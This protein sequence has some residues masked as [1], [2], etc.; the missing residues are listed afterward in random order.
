M[1][2]RRILRYLRLYAS[3]VKFSVSKSLQFRFDFF[4]RV[5]MDLIYYLVNIA[6]YKVI[7]ANTTALAGWDHHQIFIFV[8]GYCVV[9]AIQMTVFANNVH[10]FLTIV[11]RGDLDYHIVRPVSSLFMVGV[12]DFAVNSFLNLLMA[13]GILAYAVHASP[14]VY[15][16]TRVMLFVLFLFNGALVHFLLQMMLMIPVFWT[17]NAN[18]FQQAYWALSR[19]MERP[20]RIFRG[21]VWRILI[22]IL[23]FA[24]MASFPARLLLDEFRWDVLC[25][26][27]LATGALFAI[28]VMLWNRGLRAYSSASS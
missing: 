8:A 2:A 6:F 15:S 10:A 11:N 12:R 26:T 27:M 9:D 21:W 14:I 22:S 5:V 23:P 17:H 1:R 20:D 25:Y 7:F 4:F 13:F 3:F 19:C 16:L 18:G 28:V 24:L